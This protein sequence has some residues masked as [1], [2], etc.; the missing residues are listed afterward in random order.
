MYIFRLFTYPQ[1]KGK[2]Q[3]EKACLQLHL[4][5]GVNGGHLK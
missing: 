5:Q 4:L 1:T 2:I 3:E